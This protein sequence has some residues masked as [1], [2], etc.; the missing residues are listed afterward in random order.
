[1]SE[2]GKREKKK[3]PRKVGHREKLSDG[4]WQ[5]RVFLY[6]DQ[7]NKRHYHSE[8]FFGTPKEADQRIYDILK[9]H[10][11]DDPI[12]PDDDTFGTFLDEW[13]EAKKPKVKE[14]SLEH[15]KEVLDRYVRPRFG[16]MLL[17]KI[18][19]REI[20]EFY[21]D[22]GETLSPVTISHI[23]VLLGMVFRLGLRRKK[24]SK[25]PM[26]AVEAPRRGQ[27]RQPKW[28]TQ[29]KIEQF[30]A[31]AE[32]TRFGT[33]CHLG[34]QVGYRPGEI[35]GLKW[36]DLD[37]KARTLTIN[38]TIQWRKGDRKEAQ[39]WYLTDP[40]TA[41]S[42]RT[43]KI[44]Q[45]MV[46]RL[47][48]HRRAQREEQMKN[49]NVWQDHGFIFCDATGEPYSQANLRY[50]FGQ[51]VKAAGLPWDFSPYSMR[52]SMASI[53][54]GSNELNPKVVSERLGH[55][56]IVTTL[57]LYAHVSPGMQDEAGEKIARLI[58]GK[59]S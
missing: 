37:E 1:M 19:A 21:N 49:R 30:L 52:H 59:K 24:I 56:S 51:I 55:A 46:D 28:M 8:V 23:H 36:E 13:I 14:V 11:S 7:A 58:K 29:E 10:Q 47:R 41:L 39:R 18:T 4:K 17:R 43:L 48:E 40:K 33:L 35:L 53:A 9:R 54:I 12:N 34:F 20:Q 5:L 45:E 16:Q 31:V 15:Y 57:D 44:D 27:R 6:R 2:E 38:R 22:L 42:K 32:K 26:E 50:R 25:S 3:K